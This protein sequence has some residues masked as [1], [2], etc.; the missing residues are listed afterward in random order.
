MHR[1]WTADKVE[2][3]GQGGL[4]H[5]LGLVH[6]WLMNVTEVRCVVAHSSL[7]GQLLESKLLGFAFDER[8]RQW[9]VLLL[10]LGQNDVLW[11]LRIPVVRVKELVS[12]TLDGLDFPVVK[13]GVLFHEVRDRDT[14]RV[15]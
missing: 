6:L 13:L 8:C 12:V 4:I 1:H 9:G 5:L 7:E 14:S 10:L 2:G 11:G 15:R 3:I